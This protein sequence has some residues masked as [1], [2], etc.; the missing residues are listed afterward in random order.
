MRDADKTRQQLLDEV[1][2]LRGRLADVERAEEECRR[3]Q[4]VLGRFRAILEATP[5]FVAMADDHG[6]PLYLNRAARKL[7]GLAE[8]RDPAAPLLAALHPPW[9]R[10]V[11]VREALPTA[12]RA[13][14]WAGESAW[15]AADGREV[16]VLEVIL[17]HRATASPDGEVAFL[18]TIARD[19]SER[20]EA[21]GRLRR[22]EA[23]LAEAQQIARLGSWEWDLASNT[24]T[25][26]D[27][28]YRIFDLR[29]GEFGA[30]YE[31][32]LERVH[33]EDREYTRSVIERARLDHQPFD[34]DH[35]AVRPGGGVRSLHSRGRVIADAA[36]R[37]VRMVGTC[38]DV[39]ERVELEERLRQAHKL[40]AV[41]RLAGGVAHDFNNLL[42]A[43]L[44]FN[45]LLQTGLPPDAPGQDYVREIQKAG[46]RA[47]ALTRQLMAFGRRQIVAPAVLDLN[48]L[49][50]A[51]A[52]S[53]RRL[54]GAGVEVVTELQPG[55]ASVRAD[56][57][58]L[59]Q[60]LVNLVLNARD[61]MAGGGRLTVRTAGREAGSPP[62]GPALSAGG[63]PPG[64]WVSLA[65]SDTGEGLSPEARAHLFEPFFTTKGPGKG[66]GLGLATVWAIVKQSGG[67]IEVDSARGRGTTFTVWLPAAG[68]GDRP[69]ATE[70][71]GV[72][73]PHGTETV[74]LVE[75]E[76]SVRHMIAVGL[77][78]Y[79]YT[80]L[81]ARQ[82]QE[83]L[84]VC[85]G[86]AGPIHLVVTDVDMPV[87]N[88]REL[89]EQL[90]GVR[91]E[92]RVLLMS[93]YT[94]DVAVREG[95]RQ[96]DLPFL[97]KPLTPTLLARKVRE[98]L[99]GHA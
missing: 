80:V 94:D 23:Q 46:D 77:R 73:V 34:Y 24:V 67:E 62:G 15:L 64:R 75:D 22:S 69:A 87:L 53:L 63:P 21:E 5:D 86:H 78:L 49:V 65:V 83:A 58:Q 26:S 89:A 29:P 90:A 82:G 11:V 25:W 97:Q 47:A 54:V 48:A 9:A 44:G 40:E 16:P 66:T 38:Q 52:V 98:V 6:R 43:I 59:E 42:T 14:S 3:A 79:G 2:A 99:D 71:S 35:R 37:A 36:G 88:G 18:S 4:E 13:G 7:L 81:E 70:G 92:A 31:A 17:A 74:L 68:E 10:Q 72:A 96:A 1:E 45:E 39:T 76:D 12:R 56:A 55:P 41:G 60:V 57:G 19:I 8:G 32:F 91:P 51:S 93:G 28:L 61:A 30:T 20:K 84:A 85:A 33:P 95:V 50:A 27:E